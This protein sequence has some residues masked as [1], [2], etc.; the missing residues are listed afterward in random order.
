V[1]KVQKG[2]KV[3][4]LGDC[5]YTMRGI[6]SDDPVQNTDIYLAPLPGC[7][8]FIEQGCQLLYIATVLDELNIIMEH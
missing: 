8:V 4:S 1:Q 2:Q 7:E 5:H 3:R 6:L